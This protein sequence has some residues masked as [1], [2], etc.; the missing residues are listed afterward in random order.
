MFS[1]PPPDYNGQCYLIRSAN[2]SLSKFKTDY[3]V[4]TNDMIAN[5][6]I[7][8]LDWKFHARMPLRALEDMFFSLACQE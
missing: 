1:L 4:C 5:D 8:K 3:E 7:F 6:G 2:G